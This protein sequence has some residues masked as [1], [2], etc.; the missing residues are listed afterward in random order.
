M[1]ANTTYVPGLKLGA[2]QVDP[3]MLDL[4]DVSEVL[5]LI[6]AEHRGWL[7]WLRR[8]HPLSREPMVSDAGEI[9][10]QPVVWYRAADTDCACLCPEVPDGLRINLEDAGVEI[11][12][13]GN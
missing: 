2:D 8:Q 5:C 13:T 3:R 12:T 1:S 11:L 4:A 6:G 7:E 9:L 10:G